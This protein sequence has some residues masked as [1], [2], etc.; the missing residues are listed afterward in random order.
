M[1]LESPGIGGLA[2]RGERILDDPEF[3]SLARLED[4]VEVAALAIDRTRLH[5]DLDAAMDRALTA[6][7]E[8][9][10]REGRMHEAEKLAA[11][12]RLA[13]GAAHEMNNPLAIISGRAQILRRG[14]FDARRRQSLDTIV[15]QCERLS[16][17]IGDLLRYARPAAPRPDMVR[18]DDVAG[19]VATRMAPAFDEAGVALDVRVCDACACLLDD[20]QIEDALTRLLTRACRAAAERGAGGR[21]RLSMAPDAYGEHVVIEV[22]DPDAQTSRETLSRL[23]E[24]FHCVRDVDRGA[25]L[26]LAIVASIIVAHGGFVR[27]ESPPGRGTTIRAFL[28][29]RDAT[30][31]HARRRGVVKGAASG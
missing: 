12:G 25:G 29:L 28:P 23:F 1:R 27:A 8:R 22:S 11:L 31:S 17:T 3:A 14:E 9:R 2:A 10:R 4:L 5:D 15:D 7:R 19:R 26:E 20:K 16:G 18:L 30:G 13:A 24:P 21:V 6:Q